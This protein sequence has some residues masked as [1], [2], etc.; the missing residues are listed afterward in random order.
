MCLVL[1]RCGGFQTQKNG[2]MVTAAPSSLRNVSVCEM[3]FIRA[4]AAKN[5]TLL[6][7]YVF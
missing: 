3:T 7:S 6:S 1:G 2:S 5:K 4:R